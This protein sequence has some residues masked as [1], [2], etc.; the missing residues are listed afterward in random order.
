M[1]RIT[2][3]IAIAFVVAIS[4]LIWWDY[5]VPHI[6]IL[7]G[8][9]FAQLPSAICIILIAQ[10][11]RLLSDGKISFM[12]AV[13]AHC[14]IV[15]SSLF[16]PSKVGEFAKPFYIKLVSGYPIAAG[17]IVVT[18]ERVLDVIAF[19]LICLIAFYLL[20]DS[21]L[22][23]EI[24]GSMPNFPVAGAAFLIVIILA[25][26]TAP[27]LNFFKRLKSDYS[28]FSL[29]SSQHLLISTGL[30]FLVW[31]FSLLIMIAGYIFSGLEPLQFYQFL[32]L[33][34]VSTI[35]LVASFTPSGLG[36]QEGALIATIVGFGEQLDVAIAYSIGFR[37]T[38]TAIPLVIGLFALRNDGANLA[39]FLAKRKTDD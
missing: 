2:W 15:I 38:W 22:G 30:S 34:I 36:T 25:A 8:I 18:E 14:L 13:K 24:L 31:L 37:L 4:W 5:G 3:I 29:R 23:A 27:K 17:L 19:L 10:R 12:L 33:F 21:S 11:T 32:F 9:L 7:L 26:L 20:R 16:L 6:S 1:N 35:G 39:Q 28:P